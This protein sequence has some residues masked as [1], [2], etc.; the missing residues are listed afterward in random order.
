[1]L[2]EVMVDI[3]VV[4]GILEEDSQVVVP[5]G[6]VVADMDHYDVQQQSLQ[7]PLHEHRRTNGSC[8]R[9]HSRISEHKR[10]S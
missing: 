2:R 6:I 5:S 4:E 7:Q 10:A 8:P 3:L 9:K 1:M